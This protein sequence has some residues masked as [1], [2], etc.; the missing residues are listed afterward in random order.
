MEGGIAIS[1]HLKPVAFAVS[2]VGLL[3]A[4]YRLD[5]HDPAFILSPP[6]CPLGAAAPCSFRWNRSA[7]RQGTRPHIP[8]RKSLKHVVKPQF[9][10]P[11]GGTIEVPPPISASAAVS[12]QRFPLVHMLRV[13]L[14]GCCRLHRC[15]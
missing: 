5:L 3:H 15:F 13:K 2:G 14:R 10:S 4:A 7:D 11:F 12:G 1:V 6:L 9:M 8:E